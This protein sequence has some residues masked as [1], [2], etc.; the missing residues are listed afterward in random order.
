[1]KPNKP[2]VIAHQ[3]HAE[4][5]EVLQWH[6]NQHKCPIVRPQDLIKLE[7]TGIEHASGAVLQQV[8]ATPHGM[9][10]F[11]ATGK[12]SPLRCEPCLRWF[13]LLP[14]PP[15]SHWLICYILDT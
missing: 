12:P 10:W 3:P 7:C 6:A 11:E 2:V 9:P 4:A 8:R 13:L 1:M 5:L 15:A 14:L